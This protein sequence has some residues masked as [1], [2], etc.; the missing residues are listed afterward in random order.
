MSSNNQDVCSFFYP[1]SMGGGTRAAKSNSA[2]IRHLS[3]GASSSLKVLEAEYS[4]QV[5]SQSLAD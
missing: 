2:A 5:G 4:V 3:F 1:V